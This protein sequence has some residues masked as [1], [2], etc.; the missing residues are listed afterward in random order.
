MR[1]GLLAFLAVAGLAAALPASAEYEGTLQH[2]AWSWLGVFG[3]YDQAQLKRGF[4][5]YHDVCSNCHALSL[6]SY[7]N[8]AEI[9]L[10]D[11]EINAVAAEKQ[12]T[13]GP[14][15]A[16][17]MFQRPAKPSD[18]FVP[19]FANE[20]AARAANGGGY[21]P[22]LSLMVKAREGGP[23]YVYSLITGYTDAPKDFK[24]G[25]GLNYNKVFVGHQI[26]MPPPL[27]DDRVTFKDGTKATLDQETQDVVAFLNWAAEPEL[28][29]RHNL[30][31]KVLIFVAAMTVLFY[32]VKRKIWSDLHH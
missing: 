29:V 27:S 4:T 26:H 25:E 21:P 8:L 31:V 7:R 9:G 1:R 11:A 16:G 22:D 30:G 24:L 15:D 18:H 19:T 17:D 14:N 6:L 13:D 23:D 2:P 20:K 10:T 28:D 32:L 3:T 12:V 5:V